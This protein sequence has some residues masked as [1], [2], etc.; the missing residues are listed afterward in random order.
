MND[1]FKFVDMVKIGG[2]FVAFVIGSGFA[3]GQELMQFFTAY[4]FMGYG[5]AAITL[6]AFCWFGYTALKGGSELGLRSDI[7]VYKY[8]CGDALGT[9]FYWF[10]TVYVVLV[11]IIMLAGS[12]STLS[13]FSGLPTIVGR[14]AMGILGLITVLMGLNKLVDIIGTIG[15]VIIVVSLVVGGISVFNN[16]DGFAMVNTVLPEA[17]IA[18]AADNWAL[19]GLLY[20]TYMVVCLLPFLLQLSSTTDSKK[21]AA[22]GGIFGG[23][24]LVAAIVLMHSAF[25][26]NLSGVMDKEIPSLYLAEQISPVLATIFVVIILAG[27]Y[28]SAIPMMWMFCNRMAKEHTK[29]YNILCIAVV[30]IGILGSAL[31]FSTL[32]NMVYPFVGYFGIFVTLCVIYR[33]YIKKGDIE[34]YRK[35]DEELQKKLEN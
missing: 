23:V 33:T 29:K 10:T 15:P 19:S 35:M 14:V 4:G 6:I 26:A 24:A 5:A 8:Y 32:V 34:K 13:Q 30:V 1:K 31:P 2:A 17:N 28:T 3:T 16:L 9:F 11:F 20:L 25:L 12:G 27:I 22:W 21:S 18:A 7:V